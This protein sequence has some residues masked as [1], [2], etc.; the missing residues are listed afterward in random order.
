MPPISANAKK[1]KNAKS[2][3]LRVIRYL[4]AYRFVILG[5]FLLCILS[6]ALSLMGPSFAGSAVNA[7]AAG[8]G[9]VDIPVVFVYA[10]KM[11]AVYVISS[12]LTVGINTTMLLISKWVA[13]KMRRD[14][15]EKLLRLPVGFFDRNPAGDLISRVSKS[16]AKRS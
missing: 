3:L 12:L 13:R 2:T 14:V 8:K 16:E 9:K 15:F 4:A 10:K 1:P 11:L 6:N 5:I 7:A